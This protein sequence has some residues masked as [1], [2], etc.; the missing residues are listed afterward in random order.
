VNSACLVIESLVLALD[1]TT[2]LVIPLVNCCM[3]SKLILPFR[4]HA[5]F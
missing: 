5:F 4:E 3:A 2:T 1:M